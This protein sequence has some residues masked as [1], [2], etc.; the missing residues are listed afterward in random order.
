MPEIQL[1][2][3]VGV[4]GLIVGFL[5]GWALGAA[6][7]GKG[8]AG[9]R[10][11]TMPGTATG[12]RTPAMP[13]TPTTL[14][15]PAH[16]R[17]ARKQAEL[18]AAA[19]AAL[20]EKEPFEVFDVHVARVDVERHATIGVTHHVDDLVRELGE[21]GELHHL[22]R[23]VVLGYNAEGEELTRVP[24]LCFHIL[25]IH[26]AQPY[27]P[28]FLDKASMG[29]YLRILRAAKRSVGQLH[30]EPGVPEIE[31][32]EQEIVGH[33]TQLM[34]KLFA[35]RPEIMTTLL[36]HLLGRLERACDRIEEED[37]ARSGA[38]APDIAKK[39]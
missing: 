27:I 35:N 23:L 17:K 22:L 5:I 36:D 14:A 4:A 6:T 32:L 34:S 18:E 37:L 3:G 15:K 39:Q 16:G 11:P 19:A 2:I 20:A 10:M 31:A 12:H 28:V 13:G 26:E 30:A 33:V 8:A 7:K 24:E 1:L 9:Q 38:A 29:A 25:Q 21:E